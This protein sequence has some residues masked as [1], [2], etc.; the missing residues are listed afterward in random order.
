MENDSL[1]VTEER[2]TTQFK[3]RAEMRKEAA[4]LN[5][6]MTYV[7]MSGGSAPV[8]NTAQTRA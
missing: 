1:N 7:W 4:G 8:A 2:G 3:C 5:V 6:W